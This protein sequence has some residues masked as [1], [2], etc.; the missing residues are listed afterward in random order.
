MTF[1]MA[2]LVGV[3]YAAGIYLMLR[4]SMVKVIFGLIFLGH[5][6]NLMIFTV[7]RLTK[8]ARHLSLKEQP[9]LPNR[10]PTP[11]RRPSS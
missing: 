2:V 4:R 3:L 10:L 8:G 1:L 6:A 11:S 5:A 7:G 9:A